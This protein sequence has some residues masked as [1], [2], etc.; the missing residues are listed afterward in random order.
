MTITVDTAT[1]TTTTLRVAGELDLFTA[2]ELNAA[3]EDVREDV[4]LDLAEVT[5]VDST[6]L[7]V[8]IAQRRATRARGILLRVRRP[9]PNVLRA[10]EVAGF[11]PALDRA[12]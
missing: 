10:F 3:L 11:G 2:P 4:V 9:R 6:G 7:A 1:G 12:F 5:F 8:L